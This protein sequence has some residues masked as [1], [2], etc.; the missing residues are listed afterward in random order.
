MKIKIEK[1]Q[2]QDLEL[3]LQ[4]QYTAYQSEAELVG[5]YTIQPLTQTL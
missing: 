3:I 5:D 1:A 2:L 4:L